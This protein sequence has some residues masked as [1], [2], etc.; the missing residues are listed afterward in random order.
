MYVRCDSRQGF[1]KTD[2]RVQLRVPLC[3]IRDL[4]GLG[5]AIA[6]PAG[7][8]IIGANIRSEP[9]R[10]IVFAAFGLDNPVGGSIGALMSAA[11]SETSR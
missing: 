5:F 1:L 9:E 3:V 6:S 8:G 7:Y 4:A 10:T 11:V 2:K